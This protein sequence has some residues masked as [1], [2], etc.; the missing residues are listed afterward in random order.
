MDSQKLNDWVLVTGGSRG[1]GKGLVEHL[2]ASGRPVVFTYQSSAEAAH[3]LAEG[4]SAQ[5]RVCKAVRCDGSDPKAVNAVATGLVAELG[6]P[7][8]LINNAG[9]TRDGLIG[10][11]TAEQWA[12]VINT[13]LSAAWYF[14]KELAPAMMARGGGAIVQITSV[15]GLRGIAGQTNYAASKAGLIG[16]TQTLAVELARFNVRVNAVAPG[17]IETDMLKTLPAPQM[18]GIKKQ[19]PLRRLG[20]VAEVA[21]LVEYLLSES[22]AYITGQTIV[23]DGGLTVAGKAG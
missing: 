7:Y 17:F 22:A 1:I 3:A 12:E 10:A 9:I 18:A 20:Q 8:A 11:S 5:G 21:S 14:C 16:L 19:V 23:V 2:S 15:S 4:L 13:N 6:A